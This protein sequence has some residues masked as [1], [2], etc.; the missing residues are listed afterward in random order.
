MKN[1]V[2]E[3][4]GKSKIHQ[5][6]KVVNCVTDRTCRHTERLQD[7]KIDGMNSSEADESVRI[8]THMNGTIGSTI[9]LKGWEA[10]DDDDDI[11]TK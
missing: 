1:I 9:T 10:Y 3:N 7:D 2:N 6:N 8:G 4:W 5:L 11:T